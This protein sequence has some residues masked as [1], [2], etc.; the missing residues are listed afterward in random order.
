MSKK[1]TLLSLTG[2][3][4]DQL[5]DVLV[6]NPRAYMAVKGAVAEKHLELFFTGLRD[7]G[8]LESFRRGQG[9]F[10]KDFYIKLPE[11]KRLLSVECKNVQV[12][13]ITSAAMIVGYLEFLLQSKRISPLK[14]QPMNM[15]RKDLIKQ[16]KA[17][18]LELRESGM[19]RYEFSAAAL[20]GS[21]LTKLGAM[22]YLQQFDATPVSIDFQRTRNS[23]DLADGKN[24]KGQRFYRYNEVDVVAACLFS[25]TLKWEFV[26]AASKD[27][28]CHPKFRTR[29]HNRMILNPESWHH[30]FITAASRMTR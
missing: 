5:A 20:A 3:A 14:I 26:F 13:S 23:R 7:K 2:L 28:D 6:Q 9:D 25:R 18:P 19:A 10:E 29:I 22:K 17:L 8:T 30:D 11:T 24:Q 16:F 1:V 4:P 15:V 21:S 27:V 12:F